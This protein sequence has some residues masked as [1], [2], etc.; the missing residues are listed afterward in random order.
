MPR[1]KAEPEVLQEE[2]VQP[3]IAQVEETVAAEQ[4]VLEPQVEEPA[5]TEPVQPYGEDD[6][7]AA[8]E[9]SESSEPEKK[10]FYNLDFR[11]LDQDLSPAAAGVE[12]DLCFLPQPKRHER[13][14]HWRRSPFHDRPQRADRSNRN[15][16]DVLRGHRAVPR[17]Y[18]DPRNGNVG[19]K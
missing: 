12:H 15:K 13:H 11:A 10:S 2:T 19:R 3:E 6:V 18:P 17:A 16:A 8:A 14:D 9:K 7:P 4:P 1:K 5:I